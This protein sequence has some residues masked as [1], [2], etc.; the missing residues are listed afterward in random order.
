MRVVIDSFAVL[1]AIG[2]NPSAFHAIDELVR[3]QSLAL[4]IARF[5]HKSLSLGDFRVICGALG[6][7]GTELFFDTVDSNLL[8]VICKKCD[9]HSSEI[10][11]GDTEALKLH[12]VAL[13]KGREATAKPSKPTKVSKGIPKAKGTSAESGAKLTH[14]ITTK[15]PR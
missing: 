6:T 8:K 7:E 13:A 10:R 3:K 11:A 12:L 14:T 5:K 4:L 15:P 1:M 9:P 2:S